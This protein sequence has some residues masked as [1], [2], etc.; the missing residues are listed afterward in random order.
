MRRR[1]AKI[2]RNIY[3]LKSEFKEFKETV[4]GF[5]DLLSKHPTRILRLDA[6]MR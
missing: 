6:R 2:D 3:A 5:I 1:M 4:V